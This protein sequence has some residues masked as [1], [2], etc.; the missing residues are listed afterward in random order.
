MSSS[1]I[2]IKAPKDDMIVS[3]L[4]EVHVYSW[5]IMILNVVSDEEW[6]L[7]KQQ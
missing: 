5:M 4:P 3:N 6:E 1:A 7:K 2:E